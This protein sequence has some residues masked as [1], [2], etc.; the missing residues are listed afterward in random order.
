MVVSCT[1]DRGFYPSGREGFLANKVPNLICLETDRGFAQHRD[2]LC[3]QREAEDSGSDRVGL[4][5]TVRALC[6]RT[7][8]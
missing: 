8:A 4:G 6:L 2:K 7:S 3:S 1:G 5:G